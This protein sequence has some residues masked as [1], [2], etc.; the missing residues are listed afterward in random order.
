MPSSPEGPEVGCTAEQSEGPGAEQ[1]WG[2]PYQ[3]AQL[4]AKSLDI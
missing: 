3:P 1:V 2:L 4:T